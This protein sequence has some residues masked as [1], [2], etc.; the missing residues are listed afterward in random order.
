[1]T[2]GKVLV[3]D[4]TG[5]DTYNKEDIAH[6]CVPRFVVVGCRARVHGVNFNGGTNW[7]SK[8]PTHANVASITSV[9]LEWCSVARTRTGCGG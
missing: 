4:S 9:Q 5:P 6:T 1:M 3:L 7:K 2:L 8:F